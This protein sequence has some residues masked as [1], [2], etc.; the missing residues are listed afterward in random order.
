[1]V[2]VN[3][4]LQIKQNIMQLYILQSIPLIN[5]VTIIFFVTV[6]EVKLECCIFLIKLQSTRRCL[7]YFLLL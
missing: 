2:D 6:H 7:E 1:M 3:F 4:L 5:I